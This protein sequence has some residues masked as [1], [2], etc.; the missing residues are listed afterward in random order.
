MTPD[1]VA[2]HRDRVGA[3]MLPSPGE[4]LATGWEPDL[5]P[6]DTLVRQAV[7]VHASWAVTVAKA[8]GRPWRFEPA[9]AGGWVSDRT[10]FVNWVVVRQP[11]ADPGT[12]LNEVHDLLPPHVPYLL[13]SPW[14]HLDL[15]PHGLDLIGHPPLMARPPTPQPPGP[16][17]TVRVVQVRDADQLAQAEHVLVRGYPLPELEP[18]TTGEALPR[19]MLDG[20]TRVWLAWQGDE[21]VAVA[22]AHLAAGATLVE[23]VAVLPQAR[24]RG[25]GAAVTWAATLADPAQ[26][27]VLLA[28]DEGRPV[29]E[30]MGYVAIERWSAWL[31]LGSQP[32]G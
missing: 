2:C 9:W 13:V 31:R 27:A 28:S 16:G 32:S 30:R 1:A 17:P 7:D 18:L 25:A 10:G 3:S 22:A 24:H 8:A 12:L 4:H 6:Q 26:P 23:S 11:D 14:Q 15:S 29:Y 20:D 19:E 21:P 5:P